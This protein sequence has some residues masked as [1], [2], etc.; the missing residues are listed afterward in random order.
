M[1][2]ILEEEIARLPHDCSDREL[3]DID[4]CICEVLDQ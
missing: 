4:C 3:Q 1:R 2:G